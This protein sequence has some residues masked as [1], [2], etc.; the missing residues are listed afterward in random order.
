MLGKGNSSFGHALFRLQKSIQH[1][2]WSFFF[3]T[4]TILE[5]HLGCWIT[6][7]NHAAS[8]FLTSWVIWSS[9]V[10]W[11]ILTYWITGLFPG[12]RLRGWTTNPRSRLGISSYVHANTPTYLFSNSINCSFSY[13]DN[14]LL[15]KTGFG[16][17]KPTP[18]FTSSN[19]SLGRICAFFSKS[20][21]I[22][23]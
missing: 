21:K 16:G 9:I 18:K 4:G 19:S 1:W 7:M 22:F 10:V 20:S 6:L 3:F 8:N 12:F 13:V 11:K 5:S 15:I 14:W 23:S 2:I 17:P